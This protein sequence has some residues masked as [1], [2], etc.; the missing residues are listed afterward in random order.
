MFPKSL[1]ALRASLAEV[2]EDASNELPGVARLALQRAHLHWIDI[3]LQMAWC[4]ERIGCHVRAH[5]VGLEA[6]RR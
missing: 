3:E 2:I 6:A 5:R 4:D 1:E